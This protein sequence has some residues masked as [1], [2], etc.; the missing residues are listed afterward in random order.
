MKHCSQCAA[1]MDADEWVCP[2]CGYRH[3]VAAPQ[4]AVDYL[5][6]GIGYYLRGDLDRAVADYTHA[7]RLDPALEAAQLRLRSAFDARRAS[8]LARG[9][10]DQA[11][12]EC[13]EAIRLDPH[14]FPAYL[15]RAAALH[16][17][18]DVDRA[19]AD[20][21]EA[22]RLEPNH[23]PAYRNRGREYAEKG[24]HGRAVADFTEAIRLDPQFATAYE[25]RAK[26][27]RALGDIPKA[28]ADERKANELS[29]STRQRPA[30]SATMLLIWLPLIALL[31]GALAYLL[32]SWGHR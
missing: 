11:I 12:A 9:E 30:W 27:Y 21:T 25:Q 15:T 24:E 14:Y 26:A 23:A 3:E 28:A 22:I 5:N 1:E 29:K 20:N 19:I 18:G 2:Q 10:F 17:R 7:L 8:H 13:T 16:A 32:I 6:R 31:A 4:S